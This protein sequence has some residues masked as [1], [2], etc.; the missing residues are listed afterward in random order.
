MDERRVKGDLLFTRF[1][2]DWSIGKYVIVLINIDYKR[3]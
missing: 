2:V 3:G 1:F